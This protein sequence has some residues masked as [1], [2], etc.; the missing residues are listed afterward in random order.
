MLVMALE[1]YDE[2]TGKAAKAPILLQGRGRQDAAGHR[3]RLRR[4]RA[5]GLPRPHAAA[6]TCP[7]IARLYGKPEEADHR[8]AGRPDLPRPGIE[9]LADRRRLPVRQRA[10]E[11]R[12]RRGRRAGL[13]PQRRGPACTCSPRTCCPATSTPTSAPRGYRSATSRRS[14]PSCS[15][16]PRPPSTIGHLKKDAVWSVE[17]GHAAEASVAATA[18]YGTP[19]A[20]GTWLLE[21]ALNLKTPVIY[22]TI[23]RRPRGAGRQPGG[24]AGR[25]REAEADQ[26]A[27]QGLGVRRA[28]AHR[29]AGAA[30]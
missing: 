18:E 11:A 16:S 15:A 7:I 1:D 29:A 17:A 20:N 22:D 2:V 25:P 13:C 8:R 27:V 10:G 9:A 28:R 5:A 24:D 30:L 4:G 14:P 6:S 3:R 19:R 26:G 12:R 21:L 23:Q